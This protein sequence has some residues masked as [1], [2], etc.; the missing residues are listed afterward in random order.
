MQLIKTNINRCRNEEGFINVQL[1]LISIH[2]L[3]KKRKRVSF[4]IFG[5]HLIC[6]VITKLDNIS[7]VPLGNLGMS[8]TRAQEYV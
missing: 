3:L 8:E 6:F 5:I 2:F 7:A 1:C 4:Y